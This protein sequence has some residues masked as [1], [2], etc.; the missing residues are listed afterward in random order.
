MRLRYAARSDVGLLREGN[1]DSVYAGPR[2][3]AVADGM[4]GHAG[5]EVASATVIATVAVLDDADPDDL[6]GALRGAVLDANEAVRELAEAQP[7]LE[8]MGTTLTALLWNGARLGVAHIGDSRAYLLRDGVLTQITHDHTFVQRLVDEG[9]I[10]EN[11]ANVHP[12]RAMIL[13]ALD[14]RAEVDP[15]VVVRECLVGDRYLVCSDGL[16]G[17][18]STETLRDT[19]AEGDPDEVSDRLVE[20]ALRGGGPDNITV[21]VAEIVDDT[22]ATATATA[23]EPVVAGAAAAAPH[24][25]GGLADSPAVRAAA[26]LPA[27]DRPPSDEPRSHAR[28]RTGRWSLIVGIAVALAVIAGTGAAYAWINGQWYVGATDDDERTVAIFHGVDGSVAGLAL[29]RLH[30]RSRLPLDAL[31]DYERAR[32]ADGIAADDLRHARRIV[33]QLIREACPIPS[34]APMPS[35]SPSP[36]PAGSPSPVATPS[37]LAPT[38]PACASLR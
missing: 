3:L 7:D 31:P 16:S 26:T 36:G 6:V 29:S 4:G 2:L 38:P 35:T 25:A 24:R 8:G 23:T 13:R 19:L 17:V 15:D 37:P 5:G 12:Q 30:D 27:G 14:G 21:I 34:A 10:S 32:V 28:R 22:D 18:V 33:D 11:E 9:R 1:E 20:L